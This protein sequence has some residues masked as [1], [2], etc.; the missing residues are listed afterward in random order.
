M[1]NITREDWR[2]ELCI[3][4]ISRSVKN[5]YNT[6]YKYY[7]EQLATEECKEDNG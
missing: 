1:G 7:K 5:H 6:A 4:P 2:D 3:L